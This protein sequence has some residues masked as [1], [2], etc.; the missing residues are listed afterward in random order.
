MNFSCRKNKDGVARGFLK[1]FKQ[2]VKGRVGQ[3]V[4]FVDDV[5]PVCAMKRRE[6]DV[7]AQFADIVH[8][9]IRRAVNLDDIHRVAS[10]NFDATWAGSTGL[11]GG[12]PLTVKGFGQDARD[13][14]FT[15]SSHAGEDIGMGDPFAVDCI[16]ECLHDMGLP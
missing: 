1:R 3:H 11:A 9:S 7:F 15:D 5:D 13:G 6:F 4:D 16:G 8:T 14:G 12:T 10:G 2:G